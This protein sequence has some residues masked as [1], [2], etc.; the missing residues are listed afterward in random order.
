MQF[1]CS[2]LFFLVATWVAEA[3]GSPSSNRVDGTKGSPARYQ[4]GNIANWKMDIDIVD[5]C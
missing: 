2:F 5:L 4:P 3:E 1:Q